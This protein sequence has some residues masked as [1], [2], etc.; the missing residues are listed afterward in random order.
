MVTISSAQRTTNLHNKPNDGLKSIISYWGH[1][2]LR[3]R[4]Q[5]PALQI[6]K[7]PGKEVGGSSLKILQIH[8]GKNTRFGQDLIK[9]LRQRVCFFEKQCKAQI[10]ITRPYYDFLWVLG[11]P[12]WKLRCVQ[13]I[14]LRME[15]LVIF[16]IRNLTYEL[17]DGWK[18]QTRWRDCRH[19]I[20]SCPKRV[21][22]SASG[23][24]KIFSEEHYRN[25]QKSLRPVFRIRGGSPVKNSSGPATRPSN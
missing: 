11:V 14:Y 2:A 3:P 9:W 21:F 17:K 4:S 20:R 25:L 5:G 10:Y 18:K 13:K 7:R 6:G 1:L 24:W 16:S 15:I 8:A 23:I 19:L 22:H 12:W